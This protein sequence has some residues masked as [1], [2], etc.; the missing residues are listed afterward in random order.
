MATVSIANPQT[1]TPVSTLSFYGL[2]PDLTSQKVY[3]Y[4]LEY[5]LAALSLPLQEKIFF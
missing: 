5:F 2:L 3:S 4:T 1:S